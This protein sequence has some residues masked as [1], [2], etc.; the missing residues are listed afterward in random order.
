MEAWW[1]QLWA[2]GDESEQQ[3]SDTSVFLKFLPLASDDNMACGGAAGALP[4][5]VPPTDRGSLCS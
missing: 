3:C 4:P 2:Q 5:R 1:A